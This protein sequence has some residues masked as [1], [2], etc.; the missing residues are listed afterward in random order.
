MNATPTIDRLRPE[1]ETIAAG[2]NDPATAPDDTASSWKPLPLGPIVAGIHAGEIVGPVPCVIARTDGACLAYP[3]EIQSL[4]GEPESCKGWIALA[5][6]AELIEAGEPVLYMDFEDTA[7]SIVSRLLA[8]GANDDAIFDSFTYV[9]PVDPFNPAALAALLDRS[10]GLVVLDGISEAYALLGLDPYSNADAARFLT[11]LPR[12]I[13]ANGAPVLEIDHVVKAKEARGRYALGAQHKLAGIAAA[14]TAE[15]IK[16]P[17][18]NTPGKVKIKVEKDRHGHV[19]AN[20]HNG[21][22]AIA[23]ITPTDG[24]DRVAVALEPPENTSEHGF[25]PTGYME[26]VSMLIEERPGLSKR[27]IRESI[28][29]KSGTVDLALELLI[30]EGHVEATRDGKA[31]PHHSLKPYREATDD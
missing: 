12:P 18:R 22:I 8:L 13:A 28:G 23:H 29:G 9:R 7:A 5:A 30:G 27:A 2:Q 25:R 4:A 20:A 3:G 10:Y 6:A 31:H 1:L 11:M 26:R 14:Y 19:R 21:V 24:G 15:V 16:T 17:S